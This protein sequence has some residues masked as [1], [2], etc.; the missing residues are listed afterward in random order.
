[1][2]P[3]RATFNICV[4][5][6]SICPTTRMA[7]GR[8]IGQ[9]ASKSVHSSLVCIQLPQVAPSSFSLSLSLLSTLYISQTS[10]VPFFSVAFL[11]YLPNH[12][13]L[14]SIYSPLFWT[15]SSSYISRFPFKPF[16]FYAFLAWLGT[17]S[18]TSPSIELHGKNFQSPLPY[19]S[20]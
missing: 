3:V 19:P 7:G 13:E 17:F 18:S 15:I 4:Y 14:K 12:F 5:I 11:T 16:L 2:C 10:S 9:P 8:P 20:E 1:M 6:V